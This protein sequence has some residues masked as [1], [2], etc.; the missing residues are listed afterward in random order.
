M[1]NQKIIAVLL[2][3]SISQD[4]RAQRTIR[5]MSENYKLDVYFIENVIADL[6][7]LSFNQNVNLFPIP[8]SLNNYKKKLITH[9]FFYLKNGFVFDFVIKNKR[10]YDIIYCHDL[11]TLY[12]AIKLKEYFES[13]L[14]YDTHEIFIETIN[15]FFPRKPSFIK[16]L[17]FKTL[18][19]FMR[20]IGGS[21]E[22]MAI[23][24]IDILLTVNSSCLEHLQNKY[25]FTNGFVIPNLPEKKEFPTQ[26]KLRSSYNI[27]ASKFIVLYQGI[28]NEGRYLREIISSANFLNDDIFLVLIGN[29]QLKNELINYSKQNNLADKVLFV[30]YI[31]YSDLFSY[32]ADTNLGIMFNEHINLS[33]VY[34][35]ANKV[36]EYMACKIPVLLSDSP[37]YQKLL[38][39]EDVGSIISYY[40]P[41][42]IASTINNL[43]K[44]KDKLNLQGENGINLYKNEMHWE[45][46]ETYFLEL[47]NGILK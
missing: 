8:D 35:F 42:N 1:S 32:T 29:G 44:E 45:K 7:K 12:P 14:I 46:Y 40:S 2:P 34:A 17:F 21:F 20:K 37:E 23:K 28:L 26:L 10:K 30:D 11:P 27:S 3:C 33:K 38:K 41:Q 13:K 6:N 16:S 15:Q 5:S 9:S 39:K 4:S 36:T 43:S 19:Y 25:K 47:I 18:I 22:K 31:P 24:K